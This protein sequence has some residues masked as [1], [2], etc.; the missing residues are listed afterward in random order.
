MRCTEDDPELAEELEAFDENQ[1]TPPVDGPEMSP[2]EEGNEEFEG[3]DDE[4]LDGDELDDEGTFDGEAPEGSETE[5]ASE[6]VDGS[7]KELAKE[8]KELLKR[9]YIYIVN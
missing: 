7:E 1:D 4:G 2:G 9:I 8:Q 5:G 6:D 3:L